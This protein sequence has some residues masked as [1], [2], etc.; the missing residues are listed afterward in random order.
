MSSG[1]HILGKVGPSAEPPVWDRLIGWMEF[2]PPKLIYKRSVEAC[3]VP[4]LAAVLCPPR[5]SLPL[6]IPT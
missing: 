4:R 6:I 2:S 1:S 5:E 3:N